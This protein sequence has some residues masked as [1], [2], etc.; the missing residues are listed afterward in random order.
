MGG[1]L[2]ALSWPSSFPARQFGPFSCYKHGPFLMQYNVR[3]A[4]VF[5][6]VTK[7]SKQIH[8]GPRSEICDSITKKYLISSSGVHICLVGHVIQHSNVNRLN[9]P[10][11]GSQTGGAV[12]NE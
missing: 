5:A 10:F 8:F 6:S 1:G 11:T 9:L 2:K 4:A 3:T 7:L 12:N